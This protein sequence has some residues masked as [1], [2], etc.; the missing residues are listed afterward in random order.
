MFERTAAF[1][2]I[3]FVIC[4]CHSLGSGWNVLRLFCI[5]NRVATICKRQLVTFP[6]LMPDISTYRHERFLSSPQQFP[7]GKRGLCLLMDESR[8]K[9]KQQ[10]D[11]STFPNGQ[12]SFFFW[13]NHK[14]DE[15][16]KSQDYYGILG[17]AKSA[18][19]QQIRQA[20]KKRAFE[21]HPDRLVSRLGRSPTAAETHES[22]AAYQQVVED[23]AKFGRTWSP[24]W[25]TAVKLHFV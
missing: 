19:P 22:N 12:P 10:K 20:Y 23:G 2:A 1:S 15:T 13:K 11:I 7:M 8:K 25:R 21:T 24:F 6:N 9:R 14:L 16:P 5:H 4:D 3:L 17:L 18:S